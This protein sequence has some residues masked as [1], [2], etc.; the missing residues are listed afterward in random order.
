M[1]IRRCPS[2]PV[3]KE[4]MQNSQEGQYPAML[5]AHFR[6]LSSPGYFSGLHCPCVSFK[7]ANAPIPRAG[8]RIK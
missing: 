1:K 3:V 5:H 6:D 8:K 7:K 4:K 2:G